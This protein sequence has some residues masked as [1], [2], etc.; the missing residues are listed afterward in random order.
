MMLSV[1]GLHRY[2]ALTSAKGIMNIVLILNDGKRDWKTAFGVASA[3]AIICAVIC[4]RSL[5]VNV[6][7]VNGMR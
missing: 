4:L 6:L 7:A 1:D 3:L 5:E 2:I